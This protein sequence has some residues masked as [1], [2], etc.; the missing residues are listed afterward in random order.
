MASIGRAGATRQRLRD[1][2]E[3]GASPARRRALRGAGLL[4]ASMLLIPF[5]DAAAKYLTTHG[6]HTL[7]V[8]WLRQVVQCA[9]VWPVAMWVHGVRGAA[10]I[11][12]RQLL[13]LLCR[14]GCILGAT[15]CFYGAIQHM[16]L[17]NAIAITFTEPM[18]L[19]VLSAV[20]LHERVRPTR[21]LAGLVGFAAVLLV[22]KPGTSGFQPA[23]LLA[24]LASLFFSL[25]LLVTRGLLVGT[26]PLSKL[27]LLA[28]QAVPGAVGLAAAMPALWSPL[29]SAFEVSLGLSMGM[30]GACSHA[31]LILAFA[32]C[33]ASFLAPLFYTEILMQATLGY[34]FWGDVP[35]ALAVLGIAIIIG[36][37]TYLGATEEA[38]EEAEEKQQ[39]EAA[40]A[41]E[42]SE[43]QEPQQQTAPVASS[44]SPVG[45][46]E[47]A[48]ELRPSGIAGRGIFARE[49]IKRGQR[50]WRYEL[51]VSVL[52]HDEASLARRLQQM[53]THAARVDLLEHVY[54]WEGTAVEILDDAKVWNHAVDHNT[55]NH[56][57]EAAG[58]G[59]GV[60]S[61]ARRDIAAGEELTDDYATFEELRWFEA[62]CEAHGAAS[63]VA[64][65]R[66]HR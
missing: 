22:V 16:P 47:V 1:E 23:S 27:L 39:Q 52:E 57:D 28:Y 24:L 6:H 51:G 34:A 5:S 29:A 13:L 61:Y 30:V 36:V 15:I 7:Q 56:P 46:M 31:L 55:G 48:Y 21:W 10:D 32:E 42:P 40:P 41:A 43:A 33:E 66:A 12:R 59:D 18:I 65:G 2:D 4:F 35:D 37:G 45:G 64:V 20:L 25:Y 54:T 62:M 17:A 9:V 26:R 14:G 49:P 63:C 11:S 44:S 38:K 3:R 19:L 60:S 53:P 8:V 58:A 50:V